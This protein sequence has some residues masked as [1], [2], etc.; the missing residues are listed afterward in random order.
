[1]SLKALEKEVQNLSPEELHA[2]THWLTGYVAN[3]PGDAAQKAA[4]GE[5]V[6]RMEAI[7]QGQ[8]PGLTKNQFREK[9]G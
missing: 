7:I 9:L 1:M 5:G 8:T 3:L 4:V 2:F 6:L